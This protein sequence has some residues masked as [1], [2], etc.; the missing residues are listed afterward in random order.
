MSLKRCM[1]S[2]SISQICAPCV[3]A[4]GAEASQLGLLTT[5]Q[6]HWMVQQTNLSLPATEDAYFDVL[7][8][9]FAQL[10][11]KHPGAADGVS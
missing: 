7:A 2:S 1:H 6:L 10:V 11:N 9:S 8:T 5:P 3:Q 4:L